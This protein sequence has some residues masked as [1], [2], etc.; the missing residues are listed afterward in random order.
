MCCVDG[1]A[2]YLDCGNVRAGG[3]MAALTSEKTRALYMKKPAAGKGAPCRGCDLWRPP[4]K[5]GQEIR[6]A[7]EKSAQ[8]RNYSR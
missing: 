1:D 4:K 2:K 8:K 5:I 7:A 6:A 3:V